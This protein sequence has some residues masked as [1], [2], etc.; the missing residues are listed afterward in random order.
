MQVCPVRAR[1]AGRTVGHVCGR[2][3][4]RL[5]RKRRVWGGVGW[6]MVLGRGRGGEGGRCMLRRDKNREEK[7]EEKERKGKNVRGGEGKREKEE[8]NT[9]KE[10]KEEGR[11]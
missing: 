2:K 1:D 6:C 10:R 5:M 8:K 11:I 4:E 3:E 9:G 7:C